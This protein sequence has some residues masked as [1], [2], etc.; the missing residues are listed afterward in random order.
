MDDRTFEALIA[1][2]HFMSFSETDLVIDGI[3]ICKVRTR[4]YR[5]FREFFGHSPEP[6]IKEHILSFCPN[7]RRTLILGLT[8]MRLTL[9]CTVEEDITD[10]LLAIVNIRYQEMFDAY[11]RETAKVDD[12]FERFMEK[13]EELQNIS[14]V[15]A[16]NIRK[17]IYRELAGTEPPYFT[18]P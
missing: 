13:H 15:A 2:N 3:K 1:H 12:I 5:E 7:R 18:L 16:L 11:S 14:S 10:F 8:V 17:H 4:L 6:E 9:P